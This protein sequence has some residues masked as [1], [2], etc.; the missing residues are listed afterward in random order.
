MLYKYSKN[1]V[2]YKDFLSLR[3]QKSSIY[4]KLDYAVK[5]LYSED[6]YK[7]R[8]IFEK[9]QFLPEYIFSKKLSSFES[10][11]KY[12]IENCG[13]S[14]KRASILLQKS[15]KNLW[16]AYNSSKKKYP[17]K[18]IEKKSGILIPLGTLQDSDFSIL[19]NIVLYLKNITRL[20][21][22]E[23][24]KILRRDPRTIWT[25][26]SKATKKFS[27][28]T[29]NISIS[30]NKFEFLQK[31]S[32][33]YGLIQKLSKKFPLHKINENV[34]RSRFIFTDSFYQNLGCLEAAVKNLAEIQGLSFKEIS[35]L[36]KRQYSDIYNSYIDSKAKFSKKK[37]S[38]AGIAIPLTVLSDTKF[39]VLE[40]ISHFMH[41][42]IGLSYREISQLISRDERAIWAAVRAKNKKMEENEHQ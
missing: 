8:I 20:G 24:S 41:H 23:I 21:F 26:Y 29:K 5:E 14:I 1:S 11:A 39:G 17:K 3:I 28:R 33:A 18:F 25:V 6:P 35:I 2:K 7:S 12:L 36:L 40:N 27:K 30:V 4:R 16:H 15:N 9:E 19:E 37:S 38:G 32:A 22:S 13:L 10:I 31:A 42:D 34:S